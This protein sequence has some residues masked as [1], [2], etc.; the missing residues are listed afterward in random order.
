MADRQDKQPELSQMFVRMS[1][2]WREQMEKAAAA[3]KMWSDSMMPFLTT[4]AAD[5]SLF[6]AAQGGEISEV[7]KRMAEGPQLAD[8][9]SL[10]KQIYAVMAAWI[11]VQQRMAAY[12]AVVSVPWTRA[13][14]RYGAAL[15]DTKGDAETNDDWRKQF[16]LWSGITNEELIRNQRSEEFLTAQRELLRAALD[17]RLKQ[18][19]IADQMAKLFGLP[20]QQ[21]FDELTR[22]VTE[23]RRELRAHLRAQR[24][25]ASGQALSEGNEMSRPVGRKRSNRGAA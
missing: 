14:D 24:G 9:L 4:R 7:I 1:D 10:D 5:S 3:G 8:M 15:K 18:Q 19:S 12:R 22:Q 23:L 20:T 11:E 21:D 16:N 13:F 6:A 2:A 17:L 25:P